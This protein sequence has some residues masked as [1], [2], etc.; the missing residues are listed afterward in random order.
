VAVY[1]PSTGTWFIVR[2]ST[3]TAVGIPWGVSDDAAVPAD[4]DGDGKADPAVYR[5]SLGMW[6]QFRSSTNSGFGVQWAAPGDVPV[7]Q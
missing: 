6:F 4:Y 7:G 2:S 1:R 3:G 5:P